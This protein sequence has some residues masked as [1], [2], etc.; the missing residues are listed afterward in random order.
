MMLHWIAGHHGEG[1]AAETASHLMLPGRRRGEE[2]QPAPGTHPRD[3]VG[4]VLQRALS[5]ME[6]HVE[7]PLACA[8]IARRV[9][10]S[11]RQLQRL[12]ARA[13]QTTPVRHYQ[14]MRLSRA[15]GLLQQTNLSVTEI[16]MSAGFG[17]LEHF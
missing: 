7:E 17:S 2:A 3:I 15:H 11:L 10:L 13:L 8:E 12:F 6:Q 9:G 4:P 16:A 14:L 1:L 5:I